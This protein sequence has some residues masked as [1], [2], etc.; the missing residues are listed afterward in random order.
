MNYN[1]IG[2]RPMRQSIKHWV[3]N[4]S[5]YAFK[6]WVLAQYSS[7]LGGKIGLVEMPPWSRFEIDQGDD[8]EICE[9]I[10][11]REDLY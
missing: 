4:G 6:P 9:W 1:P 8:L 5:I 10:Y 7:R 2:Y 11:A 3:E